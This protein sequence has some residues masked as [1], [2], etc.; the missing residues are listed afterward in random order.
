MRTPLSAALGLLAATALVSCSRPA[1]KAAQ[2]DFDLSLDMKEL[3]GHV[4]DPGSWA[5]WHASGQN[6]TATGVEEL[7]P[8][9]EE[10]WEAAESGA[11]AVAE[12][13]NILLIPGYQ[14]DTTDWPRFAHQLIKAGLDGKAAAEAHDGPRMFTTGAAIYQVC[15][16][17]HAKYVIPAARQAEDERE[18]TSP[19]HLVDWPDDVKAM[20]TAYERRAH[21]PAGGLDAAN[22]SDRAGK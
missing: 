19:A 4:V 8:K 13:G 1:P 2:A 9:T 12:A 22:P 6:I 16:G 11:A 10:G 20:Q 3:M 18:K 17:C 7:T 14:R 5:F 15:T 21:P